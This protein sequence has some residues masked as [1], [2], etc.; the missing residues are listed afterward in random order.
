MCEDGNKTFKINVSGADGMD[1]SGAN[2]RLQNNITAS[3]FVFYKDSFNYIES[4][5]AN[6]TNNIYFHSNGYYSFRVNNEGNWSNETQSVY[7]TERGISVPGEIGLYSQEMSNYVARYYVAGSTK[8]TAI[9]NG[10]YNTRI[11]GSSVWTQKAVSTSDVRLKQD[12]QP[13][14]KFEDLYMNLQPVSFKY[15]DGYDKSEDRYFGLKAQPT[16]KLFEDMGENPDDYAMFNK[17]GIDH[18]DIKE[19]LGHDVDFDE[20]HGLDYTNMI[21]LNTHMVQKTRREAAI[22]HREIEILKAENAELKATLQAIMTKLNM[23]QN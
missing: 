18:E 22:D 13:L 1:I 11:Y 21:A 7:I 16:E 6:N 14:D 2:V 23:Q 15:I 20:E 10:S 19:R 12:F 17:F 8:C 4:L 3:R 5:E 9:G